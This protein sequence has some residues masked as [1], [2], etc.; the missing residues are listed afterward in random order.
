MPE[1]LPSSSD[2]VRDRLNTLGYPFSCSAHRFIGAEPHF[3]TLE[4][5]VTSL[6][7]LLMTLADE[8]K[9]V[10]LILHSYGSVVASTASAGRLT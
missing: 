8:G 10:V 5:D 9:D 2:A 6:G 3:L 7:R 4:D 1:T